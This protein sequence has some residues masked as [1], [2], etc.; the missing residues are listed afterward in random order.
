MS[1]TVHEHR[2][3]KA[4]VVG[5]FASHA[6]MNDESLPLGKNYVSISEHYKE[7]LEIFQ[8]Y[9]RSIDAPF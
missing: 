3:H 4:S 7:I 9:F 2:G 6:M 5:L 1:N 8:L